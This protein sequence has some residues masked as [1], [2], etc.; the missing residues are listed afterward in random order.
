MW[1][2]SC[3]LLHIEGLGLCLDRFP[4]VGGGVEKEAATGMGTRIEGSRDGRLVFH[5]T[6]EGSINCYDLRWALT[7]SPLLTQ[8]S[9][10]LTLTYL[11]LYS[12]TDMLF[13]QWP[14]TL[15]YVPIVESH[16][17][18]C[19]ILR[20]HVS[21]VSGQNGHVMALLMQRQV[22]MWWSNPQGRC[23]LNSFHASRPAH[24]ALSC[25]QC[26]MLHFMQSLSI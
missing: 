15:L 1:A 19:Y 9:T 13:N 26:C 25:R 20:S 7:C 5:G 23:V 8:L 10:L 24:H 6:A 4:A 12:R 2:W 22:P 11:Q 18:S 21:S 16:R 17:P 14:T 3:L